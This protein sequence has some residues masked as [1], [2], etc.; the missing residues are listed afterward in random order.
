MN[1]KDKFICIV[2]ISLHEL[3]EV[4]L[5]NINVEVYYYLLY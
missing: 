1:I 5:L 4:E 3:A 2:I